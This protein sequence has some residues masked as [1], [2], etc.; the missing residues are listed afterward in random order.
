MVENVGKIHSGNNEYCGMKLKDI[1]EKSPLLFSY[2]KNNGYGEDE[3]VYEA[4]IQK[5]LDKYDA[6]DVDDL[7]RKEVRELFG[8]KV[9]RK[10]RKNIKQVMSEIQNNDLSG[11]TEL[12]KSK[13]EGGGY[14]YRTGSGEL[15]YSEVNGVKTYYINGDENSIEKIVTDNGNGNSKTTVYV[16]GNKNLP[17]SE[18]IINNNDTTTIYYN[19]DE[20]YRLT[21]Q[22]TKT[23]NNEHTVRYKYEGNNRIVESETDGYTGDP[24][25]TKT[26]RYEKNPQGENVETVE[27]SGAK[28]NSGVVKVQTVYTDGDNQSEESSEV[29]KDVKSQTINYSDGSSKHYTQ[30]GDEMHRV[31]KDEIGNNYI[32]VKMPL[33]WSIKKLADTFGIDEQTILDANRNQLHSLDGKQ[34]F[35]ADADIII[36]IPQKMP[37]KVGNDT[38]CYVYK[39]LREI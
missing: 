19:Y 18:T 28:I 7:S 33:N 22:K 10:E 3:V 2:F 37:K 13:R 26:V 31:E 17:S 38:I 14:N 34:Y 21:S 30:I 4:E 29:P 23:N 24:N 39:K 36:N 16:D 1:K 25:S 35:Y 27:F 20:Q 11:E 9:E 15:V 8:F 6:E 32:T 12:L 5:I